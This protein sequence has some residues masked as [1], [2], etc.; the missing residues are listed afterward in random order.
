MQIFIEAFMVS[1]AFILYW[2]N[3]NRRRYL[4][5]RIGSKAFINVY[6]VARNTAFMLGKNKLKIKGNTDILQKG[7]ILYSL[8]FGIWELMPRALQRYGYRLSIIVNRYRDDK[9][10]FLARFFDTF[11]YNYRSSGDIKIFYK[12]DTIEIINFIK[13]C[14][15]LGILVDG[16][17][18]YSKFEK[19]KKLS[20]ICAVPLVPFATYRKNGTGVLEIGCN[21]DRVV[22]Q[23]PYDYVW[24]YKSRTK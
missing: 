2:C 19:A 23:R 20:R 9:T 18:F 3:G 24:F 5:N 12:G 1:I 17:T 8:H 15:V 16:N 7:G 4:K 6:N 13:N 10:N 14:G 22:K 21:L 11:L